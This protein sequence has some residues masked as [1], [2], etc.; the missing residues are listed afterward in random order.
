MKA[1]RPLSKHDANC[2]AAALGIAA[3]QVQIDY[4]AARIRGQRQAKLNAL[5]RLT[6]IFRRVSIQSESSN[7][8]A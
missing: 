5:K 6:S 3:E 2:I 1:P 7:S 8:H 4:A